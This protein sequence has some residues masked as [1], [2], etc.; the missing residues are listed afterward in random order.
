MPN[1][2]RKPGWVSCRLVDERHKVDIE[3]VD[4]CSLNRMD[5]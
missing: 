3:Y 2:D 5:R 1:V 4:S